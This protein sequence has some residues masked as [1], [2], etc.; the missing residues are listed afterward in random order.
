M[1]QRSQIYIRYEDEN[2]NKGLTALYFQWNY[3]CRMISRAKYG[4][5]WIKKNYE[6]I[7]WNETLQKLRR[8]FEINFDM[9]DCVLSANIIDEFMECG[10]NEDFNSYVFLDQD[11][12]NGKLF[13]DILKDGKIKYAFTDCCITKALTPKEYMDS[14]DWYC[15]DYEDR[16]FSQINL[17]NENF[18]YIE[19]NAEL[20]TNEELRE[21]IEADYTHII[22]PKF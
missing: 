21:F 13:I 5:E 6:Y 18:K 3:G 4:I 20:M 19:E 22:A 16:K 11:N 1:G 10:Q 2:N 17:L 8:I 9:V 14:E 12:N 7:S 15:K